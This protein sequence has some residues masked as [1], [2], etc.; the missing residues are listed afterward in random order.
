M[1]CS[2]TH[3]R[4]C[5]NSLG[6]CA[7]LAGARPHLS[8]VYRRHCRRK[9][10]GGR[11]PVVGVSPS[12][13]VTQG[14]QRLPG[15]AG[16]GFMCGPR[17][18]DTRAECLVARHMSM[19]GPRSRVGLLAGA[20]SLQFSGWLLGTSSRAPEAEPSSADGTPGL[21]R[22][23][24]EPSIHNASS[25]QSPVMND[26]SISSRT[27]SNRSR[28]GDDSDGLEVRDEAGEVGA[29]LWV[30]SRM[31]SR[32]GPSSRPEYAFPISVTI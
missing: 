2:Q 10:R 17:V 18:A 16:P 28:G 30:I 7:V 5:R 31:R 6:Q 1:A 4:R 11:V 14:R 15:I 12:V 27:G 8:G 13:S 19:D 9:W 20:A 24:V 32:N 21:A 29:T 26:Q 25:C 3:F 23:G 22:S